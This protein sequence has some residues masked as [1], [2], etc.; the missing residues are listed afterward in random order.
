MVKCTPTNVMQLLCVCV[1]VCF[2]KYN[3]RNIYNPLIWHLVS[4]CVYEDD[5]EVV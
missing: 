3:L 1:H 5:V 2:E 4:K